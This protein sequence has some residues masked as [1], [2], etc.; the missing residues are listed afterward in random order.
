MYHS[1]WS[2]RGVSFNHVV[3]YIAH[4]FSMDVVDFSLIKYLDS[5]TSTPLNSYP[6]PMC[7]IGNE[8]YLSCR[9]NILWA[10]FLFLV[11]IAKSST[12]LLKM[13]LSP[14]IFVTSG[15][16]DDLNLPKVLCSPIWI[17]FA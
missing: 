10:V 17:V 15:K 9:S 3:K 12:C 11:A 7:L 16:V 13:Y 14:S 8:S 2:V 5:I 1:K 6:N 4:I